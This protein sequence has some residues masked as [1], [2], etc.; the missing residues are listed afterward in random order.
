MPASADQ[1]ARAGASL[2]GLRAIADVHLA[3][4]AADPGGWQRLLAAAAANAWHGFFNAALIDAQQPGAGLAASDDDW[5]AAGWRV[6]KGELGVWVIREQDDRTAATAVFTRDQ[7]R[8]SRTGARP[9]LPG[10]PRIS[11]GSPDR[12]LGALVALAR[13]RGYSVTRTEDTSAGPFTDWDQHTISIPAGTPPAV[14]AAALAHQLAHVIRDDELAAALL[15]G[16]PPAVRDWPHQP[17]G[18]MADCFGAVAVEAD[19]AAW[20]V[21]TRLGVDPAEAGI[22]FPAARS[23]AGADLRSPPARAIAAAGERIVAAADEITAHAGKV[24][25]GL[26][27]PPPA[28]ALAPPPAA[29]PP[30]E[31]QPRPQPAR[32]PA[33]RR[34]AVTDRP[35]WPFPDQDLVKV[36]AA[37]AAYFRAGLPRSWAATYL[38][39]RG[40]GPD[41][42][43]RWQLGYAPGGWTRLLDHL[44]A[45]GYP[46]ALVE[47]A[48]L[49][50]RSSR[51]T[52]IDVFRNRV[53]FPIR[54]VHGQNVA[55][56]GRAPDGAAEGTPRYLNS[57]TTGVFHKD[58]VLYGLAEAAAALQAGARPVL[59]EGYLDVIAVTEAGRF[60]A[61][62]H[63]GGGSRASL[64]GVAPG[65]TSL[66]SHQMELLAATCDLRVHCPLLVALDPDAAGLR[67]AARDFP[68]ICLSSPAATVPVLPEG[69]DPADI[70]RKDGPQALAAA[71]AA[72]EHPLADVAIDAAIEPWQDKLQSFEGQI[73]AVRAAA[74]LLAQTT[75][76]DP[77]AQI[78]RVAERTG[79]PFTQVADEVLAALTAVALRPKADP[80]HDQPSR[81]PGGS[82]EFPASPAAGRQGSRP[83]GS[84]SR[85]TDPRR[86][87]R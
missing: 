58:Q 74:R 72:G 34:A 61:I 86:P 51:G 26:P 78:A 22:T 8:P 44:R 16:E 38:Q 43:R 23:W 31:A 69:A 53:M 30:P 36:N 82:L 20:L 84:P 7:V 56:A 76:D 18:I 46:D 64:A 35:A 70:F 5:R 80:G 48:G 49:A 2:A 6:R 79:I 21:L 63:G 60:A 71:L 32:G 85:R 65:G 17:G 83:A 3:S 37:A 4:C 12:A 33:Q 27:D 24:L 50:R 55:F 67:A 52:L 59:V 81:A 47:A 40:F 1:P 62:S 25:A 68:L 42:T 15:P 57:P 19:S 29:Q 13:R 28:Q 45:C 66:S 54:G 9:P 75:P 39:G 87:H 73:G 10:T 77:A 11:A 41:I 14:A